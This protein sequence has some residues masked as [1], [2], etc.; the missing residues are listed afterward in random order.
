MQYIEI[1]LDFEEVNPWQEIATALLAEIDFESFVNTDSGLK[2]YIQKDLYSDLETVHNYLKDAI[3][4]PFKIK[5]TE[6]ED[7][8]WNAA[9]EANFD[10]IYIEDKLEIIAPFH[11]PKN[12]EHTIIINPQMSFGT[13]HHETTRMISRYLL[14][15]NLKDQKILDMGTGTG[16]LA[17]LAEQLGAK[18]IL[19]V[20]IE[21]W[22]FNNAKEN[23]SLNECSFI[24]VLKGDIDVVCEGDFDSIIANINKNVLLD[25]LPHYSEKLKS[26]G[27]LYLSGFFHSDVNDLVTNAEKCGFKFVKE[28]NENDWSALQFEKL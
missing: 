3:S 15:A 28:I 20:D 12:L 17:V 19:A 1:E 25:H 9:W 8:N 16:V 6:I 27:L 10:P 24:R 14:K 13:G 26:G 22:A 2:A 4:I 21:D 11:T 18:D 5:E 23:L 7:Q